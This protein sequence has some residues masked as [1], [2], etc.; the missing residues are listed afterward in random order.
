MQE[1]QFTLAED[2]RFEDL[3]SDFINIFHDCH[4]KY[5]SVRRENYIKV[6]PYKSINLKE[7]CIKESIFIVLNLVLL[8]CFLFCF[9][10]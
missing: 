9:E 6:Y 7:V 10:K 1:K 3:K 2:N 4:G 5:D 8:D